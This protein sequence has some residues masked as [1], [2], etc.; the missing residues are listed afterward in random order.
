MKYVQHGAYGDY[1]KWPGNPG[2]LEMVK[3]I[4]IQCANSSAQ[5]RSHIGQ[6]YYQDRGTSDAELEDAVAIMSD[7]MLLA[8]TVGK[9]LGLHGGP[10]RSYLAAIGSIPFIGDSAR[11]GRR[12]EVEITMEAW[13]AIHCAAALFVHDVYTTLTDWY[14]VPAPKL[15]EDLHRRVMDTWHRHDRFVRSETLGTNIYWRAISAAGFYI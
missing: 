11:A 2:V 6:P 1:T 15:W 9:A 13:R 12:I 3:S 14:T 8:R 10:W 5:L 7:T 4:A